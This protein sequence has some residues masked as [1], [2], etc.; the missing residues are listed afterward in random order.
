[1]SKILFSYSLQW[2][3]R[4]LRFRILDQ[5]YKNRD[6]HPPFI[7]SNGW[8]IKQ[9]AHPDIAVQVGH[10]WVR[11]SRDSRD[12]DEYIAAIDNGETA[13]NIAAHIQQALRE[14][15]NHGAFTQSHP[16]NGRCTPENV[17]PLLPVQYG[18]TT[19]YAG[20]IW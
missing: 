20:L 16:Q 14:W 5:A 4:S 19:L 17:E 8:Q 12:Q 10:I 3:G 6:S 15:A 7:S 13:A 1:M 2:D 11:G 18:V 9:S